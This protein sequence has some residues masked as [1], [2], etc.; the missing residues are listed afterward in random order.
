VKTAYVYLM[1]S[2]S[3]TLYTGVTTNLERRVAEHQRHAV[4]GFTRRYRV[5]RLVYFEVW[6]RIGDAIRRETEIK[7]WRRSKKIALIES[8]NPTWA[9][10][11]T[12]WYGKADSSPAGRAQNDALG[13]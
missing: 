8:K 12:G 13:G 11:A 2:R 6:G 9:D 1:A 3:R 7:G 4:P 5:E 10:L